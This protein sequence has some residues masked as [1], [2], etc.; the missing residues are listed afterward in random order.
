MHT[1]CEVVAL[2]PAAGQGVRLGA[3][4]PKALVPVAGEPLLTHAVR[5]LL[6]AGVREV[7]VAAP[8]DGVEPIAEAARAAAV[9]APVRVVPGGAD[10]TE[11]VRLALD[12]VHGRFDVV[13]VHD[14]ARAFTPV[15]TI[16]AVI[17]A[18]AAGA[19]VAI[20]VL[21]VA[22]T[23]KVVDADGM[24]IATSDRSSLRLVQ[25]PQGFTLDVLRQAHAQAAGVATDDS[26]LVE[27][28]G[29]GVHTVEG[30][31]HAMKVTTPFDLAIAEAVFG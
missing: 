12:A 30:H 14:A 1:T 24:V 7:I 19:P 21:P 16:R 17:S 23:V 5:R 6:D 18:V 26:A 9:D 15:E 11:S 8:P 20:P 25:T 3:G 10:R 29:I 22:D 31:P 27:R 13:L 2:V 4:L 28:L